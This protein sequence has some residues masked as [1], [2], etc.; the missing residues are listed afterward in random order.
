[1]KISPYKFFNYKENTNYY[2]D[3]YKAT[4]F[5]KSYPA[6]AKRLEIFLSLIK[7]YKPK[8]IIDAGCGAGMPLIKIK[9]L[10]FNICGYDKAKNMV[11]EAK[12]NLKK[13][14]LNENLI[15][16]GDFENPGH[17]KNNSVNCILG[18]GAFYYS[19]KFVKT[20]IN[21]K[22]KLKK[23]GHL[24]FSLRNQL[25]DIAT[26]NDYSIKF[27]SQLYE[28]KRFKPKIKRKYIKLFSGYTN[29]KKFD[30][31]NLDD[32]KVFSTTH[33]PLTIENELL[34]KIGLKLN[35]IYFY[36]YHAIPPIFEN[37]DK[38]NFRKQSYKIEKPNDWRG[39]FIASGFV[40]DCQKVK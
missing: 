39:F 5:K 33:N 11:K 38:I 21:Q 12:I 4:D 8:K 24:I 18:M 17:I 14:N 31:K 16:L 6:N 25:F 29:R 27:Y 9:K 35:G 15:E 23:N 7:K 32:K 22:K 3:M 30:L 19:K 34:N 1:M 2:S 36:H 28:I 37:I 13:N 20:L 40:V 26:L 10:G